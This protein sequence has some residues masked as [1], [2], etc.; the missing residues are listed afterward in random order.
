[1]LLSSSVFDDF[2]D[3]IVIVFC[4][5]LGCL[6]TDHVMVMMVLQVLLI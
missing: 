3:V 2:H 6:G 5:G 1:M 4:S